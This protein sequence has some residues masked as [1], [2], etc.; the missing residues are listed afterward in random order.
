[1]DHVTLT[2]SIEPSRFGRTSFTLLLPSRMPLRVKALI[3][4]RQ[5]DLSAAD[6]IGT[7]MS[8]AGG[9]GRLLEVPFGLVKGD[10]P[11]Y[12]QYPTQV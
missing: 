7:D 4:R 8:E 2:S 12:I 11:N 10:R 5:P 1:M 6:E 9:R 3:R